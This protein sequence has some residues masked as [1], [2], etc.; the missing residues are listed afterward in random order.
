MALSFLLCYT[1]LLLS[2][3]KEGPVPMSQKR[4][5]YLPNFLFLTLTPIAAIIGIL[6]DHQNNGLQTWELILFIAM[7]FATGLSITGGYHRHFAHA[8]YKASRP[9]RLFYLIFGACAF[10]NSALNWASDHRNHHKYVDTD[11]DPYNAAKGFWS[12]HIGWIFYQTPED[13]PLTNVG[14]LMLD[15]VVR[16]QHKYHWQ[17]GLLFGF[18][19]PA[20]IGALCGHLIEGIIWGGIVR[21]VFVHHMTFFINS[22][23]HMYGKQPYSRTDTSRDSWWL[24]FLTNGEGYHNFHHRFPSDYRNGIAWYQWDPT[25]WL[26]WGLHLFKMTDKLHRIP[27]HLVLKARLEVDA[28]EAEKHLQKLSPDVTQ[29]VRQRLEHARVRMDH[30]LAQWAETRAKIRDLKAAAW[31]DSEHTRQ[32]WKRKLQDYEARVDEAR[33]QWQIALRGVFKTPVSSL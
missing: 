6:W 32:Q 28:L 13:R 8:A 26:I 9:V 22:L 31:K 5:L 25:K 10:E 15:P 27:P 19:L 7:F 18:G 33:E 1:D 14:D 4:P 24:A 2:Q 16:W 20:I 11:R 23:A 17:I 30:A 29:T 21:V 3:P 12:S